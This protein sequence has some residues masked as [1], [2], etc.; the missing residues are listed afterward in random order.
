MISFGGYSAL[1][2]GT[3]SAVYERVLDGVLKPILTL[4]YHLENGYFS[5]SLSGAEM[6]W[7]EANHPEVN[8]LIRDLVKKGRLSLVGGTYYGGILPMLTP[9]ER[10]SQIEKDTTAIRL[11]YAQRT[12]T[13]FC[14]AQVFSPYTVMTLSLCDMKRIIIAPCD[15]N[16]TVSDEPFIMNELDKSMLFLPLNTISA[17]LVAQY[18][19]GEISFSALEQD[20]ATLDGTIHFLNLDQ[21]SQ[22]GISAEETTSLASRFFSLGTSDITAYDG[23]KK[24]G[25]QCDGW[26][27][28]DAERFSLPCFNALFVKDEALSYMYGRYLTLSDFA[29]TY[30]KN[31][32]IKKQLEKQLLKCGAGS[33]YVMDANASMLRPMMRQLFFRNMSE[34]ELLLPG[35]KD[36]SFPTQF[37]YD[38]DGNEEIFHT[39]KNI[40]AMI[41]TFGGSLSELFHIPSMS[42]FGTAFVPLSTDLHGIGKGTMLRIFSDVLLSEEDAKDPGAIGRNIAGNGHTLYELTVTNPLKGE[43]LASRDGELSLSKGYKFRQNTILLEMTLRNNGKKPIRGKAGVSVPLSMISEKIGVQFN[44]TDDFS[45][46]TKT[47]VEKRLFLEHVRS[48]RLTGQATVTLFCS[49]PFSL[50]KDDGTVN[51]RTAFGEEEEI[52]LHM[53]LVP[54][55]SYLLAPGE[56]KVFTIGLRIEKKNAVRK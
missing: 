35:E 30:K 20:A 7:L 56:S 12:N 50:Y 37:D 25:Y 51:V 52:P 22:G 33:F 11:N 26:Y 48:A 46:I 34:A 27:G 23:T 53:L 36:F 4:L 42:N 3:P 54:M 8:M 41:S 5:L 6:E 38:H 40:H 14:P 47:I 49:E 15:G 17:H 44:T 19:K 28:E 31:K 18:G 29:R 13:F 21:L 9:K 16:C 1:G 45:K 39:G 24:K 32:D 43:Y 55:V 10:S 2:F